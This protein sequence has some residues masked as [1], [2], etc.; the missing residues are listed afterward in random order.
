MS[1]QRNGATTPGDVGYAAA[2]TVRRSLLLILAL[3]AI[4]AAT[5]ARFGPRWSMS[6]PLM[7][8]GIPSDSL[9]GAAAEPRWTGGEGAPLRTFYI[10]FARGSDTGSGASRA[11]AWKHAPGDPAATGRPAA[12]TPQP[13]D[14]L[15]FVAGTRYFGA[16]LAPWQ[17]A[18]ARPIVIEGEGAGQTAAIDGSSQSAQPR[19]CDSQ[20]ECL[21][22]ATWR[23]LSIAQFAAPLSPE[24]ALAQGGALL[25]GAQWP[26]P[27]DPF[28][29]D[30][31]ESFA[32]A[33]GA[34]LNAGAAP[35]PRAVAAGLGDAAGLRIAIWTLHNS[36]TERPVTDASAGR[37]RF[38]PGAA[39]TYTDRPSRFALRGHPSLIS[40]AGEFALLSDGRTV[41]FQRG[42]TS[43]PVFASEG[44]SG[45]DLAEA[46]YVVVRGL[47]FENFAD[48]RGKVRS[49]IPILAMRKGA[50]H[51]RVTGNRFANLTLRQG[52]GAITLWDGGD[53]TIEGNAIAAVA[54]G[55]GMRLLRNAGLTIA[56]NDISRL[57]RTGIMLMGNTDALVAG[58]RIHDIMGIHGN[59]ISVYLGNRRTR[60]VANSIWAAKSPATFQGNGAKTPPAQ[61]LLFAR[62]LLVAPDDALGAL[63][64]WGRQAQ[65]V[66]VT[67][68]VVLGARKGALRLNPDDRDVTV[69]GNVLD[70]LVFGA[71]YPSG[72]TVRDNTFRK[73]GALQPRYQP[74]DRPTLP[75]RST[76][77]G[78]IPADLA[79]FCPALASGEELAGIDGRDYRQAIGADFTCP[80]QRR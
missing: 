61:D 48:I 26:D 6:G 34:D 5:A 57:G 10:D 79:A 27:A 75:F 41:L 70:G 68:N 49:G 25:A 66:R 77:G 51:V 15:L 23:Q 28:Y 7:A 19:P 21:G 32:E 72:W 44:R 3:A 60:V 65:G 74:G 22:L 18:A 76:G 45:I 43:G 67:G 17:G 24:A 46:R 1:D 42:A 55:S 29:A 13:G 73:L 31:I 36:I 56:G 8:V 71:A 11:A 30:E 40:R 52:M 62:N 58:N 54:F 63:V 80:S 78:A 47:G 20:A 4:A 38:D 69:R 33:S 39:R 2:V 64:S 14:R 50:A 53:V 9:S 59:G 35:I 37:V 12:F 16:I